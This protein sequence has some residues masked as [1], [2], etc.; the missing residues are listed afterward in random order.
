MVLVCVRMF[1]G[2]CGC[3]RVRVEVWGFLCEEGCPCV[4]AL[5]E[6]GVCVCVLGADYV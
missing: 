3:A 2:V 1:V 5:S 6:Y 4:C